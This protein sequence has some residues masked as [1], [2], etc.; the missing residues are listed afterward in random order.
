M[1]ERCKPCE[2]YEKSLKELRERRTNLW[3]R[4]EL[5][6]PTAEKLAADHRHYIA[7][8][9]RITGVVHLHRNCHTSESLPLPQTMR[10]PHEDSAA[11]SPLAEYDRA[12]GD[13]G[14]YLRYQAQTRKPQLGA[15]HSAATRSI[16]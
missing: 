6:D 14:C 5:T 16:Y 3:R 9:P 2:R 13:T 15:S 11:Q 10:H 4:G 12:Y 7:L 1:P 8:Q